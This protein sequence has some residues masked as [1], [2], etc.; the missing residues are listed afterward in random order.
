VATTS[1]PLGLLQTAAFVSTFDRFA[2]PPLLLAIAHDFDAPLAA[3]VTA[4]GAYFLAYGLMQ[5][6]WGVLSD[7]L[8]LVRTMRLTLFLAGSCSLASALSTGP[9]GLAIT[10][11]LAGGFFAATYPACLIYLGD[12]VPSQDRQPQ[13]A[14]LMVGI[15]VGTAAASLGAGLVATLASWRLAFVVTGTAALCLVL[16]LRALPEP[17]MT[18]GSSGLLSPFGRVLHSPMTL[19]VLGLA[20][21]EGG[22][23]L[24]TLTLVPPAIEHLG[25]SAA[26]AGLVAGIYGLSVL[27]SSR[28]VGRA[29]GRTRPATLIAVGALS[30]LG[31]CA[32]LTVSQEP[33]AGVLAAVLLGVAWTYM[34]SSL[35]TWATDVLPDDRAT[36]VS[37]FAGSLFCGSAIA[38]LAVSGLADAGRYSAIF[39]CAAIACL[40]LG[41][42]ATTLRSRW[43]PRTADAATAAAT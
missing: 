43:H 9:L 2:M 34:H 26:V 30:A 40:L 13:I 4:A 29:A 24:G 41:I 10:R 25:H 19:A 5:P 35:Q 17:P 14:R 37:L 1:R 23:L 20:F 8:G 36:V 11:A 15:A 7:R 21:V 3:V 28:M 39:G 27:V 42:A 6:V 31:A 32:L 12:T 16:V 22:A 33:L 18:R 38:A